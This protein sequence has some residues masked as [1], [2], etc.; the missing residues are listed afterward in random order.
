MT[1][2]IES[3]IGM[4]F[5]KLK[6]ASIVRQGELN[7]IIDADPKK[8][9]E[10]VNTIIG[11]DKLDTAFGLMKD[12]VEN[13]R[14]SIRKDLEYDDTDIESLRSNLDVIAKEIQGAEPQK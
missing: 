9:K 8:F 3:L 5:D 13:F 2:E 4:D 7:S 12:V 11:I 10:L 14:S 1:Q 6:I